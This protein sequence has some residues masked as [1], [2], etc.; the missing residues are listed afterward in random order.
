V[1][2]KPDRLLRGASLLVAIL[3]SPAEWLIKVLP[4]G[5][6]PRKVEPIHAFAHARSGIYEGKV[7]IKG[8]V[9]YI[10]EIDDRVFEA[11]EGLWDDRSVL[12]YAPDLRALP[13]S[14]KQKDLMDH[15]ERMLN[16]MPPLKSW[17]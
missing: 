16:A 14:Q 15:W 9:Y 1:S 17:R 11:V 2:A 10:R 6:P 3:A 12:H 8:R 7:S 4:Q 13:L 5:H